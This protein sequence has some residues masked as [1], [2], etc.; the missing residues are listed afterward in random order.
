MPKR[1]AEYMTSR[2]EQIL[3][4]A[5]ESALTNGWSRTTIDDVGSAAGL[6]KGAVYVHFANKRELLAGLVKRNIAEIEQIANFTTFEDLRRVLL[7]GADLLASPRGQANAIGILEFELE[8]V[9]DPELG[10]LLRN[11]ASRLIEIMMLVVGR[12]RPDL[13]ASHVSAIALGLIFVLEG[14]RSLRAVC[15]AVSQAQMREVLER[16]LEALQT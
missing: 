16:Q 4:A 7:D 1:S 2:R 12:L 15:D 6:S 11:G 13:S 9:R 8:A 5:R 3:D 14:M 10:H